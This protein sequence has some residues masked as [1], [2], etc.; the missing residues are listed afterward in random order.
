M[1]LE[2]IRKMIEGPLSKMEIIID[3]IIWEYENKY[4]FLKIVLDKEGGLDLDT[5]CEAT[6]II[7]PLIDKLDSKVDNYILDVSSKERR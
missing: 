3:D 6:N 7:N 4:K 2:I 5:I 1:D